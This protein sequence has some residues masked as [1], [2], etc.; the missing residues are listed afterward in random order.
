MKKQDGGYKLLFDHRAPRS[1]PNSFP[2]KPG[3][4]YLEQRHGRDQKN[5]SLGPNNKLLLNQISDYQIRV[6][7]LLCIIKFHG[8]LQLTALPSARQ[9]Q[10]PFMRQQPQRVLAGDQEAFMRGLCAFLVIIEERCNYLP[11]KS[12]TYDS[13]MMPPQ[14]PL[15]SFSADVH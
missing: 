9:K 1:N 13:P 6:A 4:N 10:P 12:N 14:N 11:I 2:L 8:V 3:I 15:R 7:S 5:S